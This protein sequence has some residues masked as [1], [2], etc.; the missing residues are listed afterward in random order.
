LRFF[1]ARFET[2]DPDPERF[3]FDKRLEEP[4]SMFESIGLDYFCE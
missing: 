4:A 1:A 2:I 3:W